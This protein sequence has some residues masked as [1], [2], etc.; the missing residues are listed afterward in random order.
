M[1]KKKMFAL[2]VNNGYV[3]DVD[4]MPGKPQLA[5]KCTNNIDN[6]LLL[7]DKTRALWIAGLVT[8]TNME[9]DEIESVV[10]ERTT[11]VVDDSNKCV[12]KMGNGTYL[13]S[14]DNES[15]D[16]TKK[17]ED[18][19]IAVNRAHVFTKDRAEKLYKLL[20]VQQEIGFIADELAV[21]EPEIVYVNRETKILDTI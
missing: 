9:D 10:V 14:M 13:M 2:K 17:D 4:T 5:L 12:I 11:E 21:A 19:N 6:A 20:K 7:D 8:M 1:T 18:E 15:I 3:G 16:T